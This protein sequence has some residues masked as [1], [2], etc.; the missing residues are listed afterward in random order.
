MRCDS[1]CFVTLLCLSASSALV[2]PRPLW[3]QPPLID[4]DI[5]TDMLTGATP[6]QRQQKAWDELKAQ[7]AELETKDPK[8]ALQAYTDFYKSHDNMAAAVAIKIALHMG[9]FVFQESSR[10]PDCGAHL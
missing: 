4:P 1:R 9:R 10:Y 8:A 6:E 2:S 7:N 5:T 3:A